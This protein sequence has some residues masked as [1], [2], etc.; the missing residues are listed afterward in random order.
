[1]VGAHLADRSRKPLYGL[2][3]SENVWERRS[4]IYATSAF[5][6]R[7]ELDDTFAIAEMRATYSARRATDAA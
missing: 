4:A 7:G 6:R 5:L 1:V 2:A 3:R